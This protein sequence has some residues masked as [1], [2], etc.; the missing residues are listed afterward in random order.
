VNFAVPFQE[1]AQNALKQL[2]RFISLKQLEKLFEPFFYLLELLS[3]LHID[4]SSVNVT[5][6][7]ST[8]PIELVLNMFIVGIVIVII[9]SQWQLF[10]VMSF[11]VLSYQFFS[12]ATLFSFRSAFTKVKES[13]WYGTLM[14]I[15]KNVSYF[16]L[17]I[18][19][20]AMLII[21]FLDPFQ[22]G[23]VCIHTFAT[24]THARLRDTI[25]TH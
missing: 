16:F 22:S 25:C 11:N 14:K 18:A 13:G 19:C 17:L 15:A 8:A 20:T 6:L 9:D 3:G 23:L 7:G 1:M 12:M 4:F 2:S 21:S 24:R 5:C 10:R